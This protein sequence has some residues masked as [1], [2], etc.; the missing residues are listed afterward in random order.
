MS[1]RETEA[2]VKKVLQALA[3]SE[4]PAPAEA[5][6]E[7]DLT[8][9]YKEIEENLKNVLGTKA[10]IK[11]KSK[12]RGKIEI[13]YYSTDDMERILHLIYSIRN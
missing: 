10:S 2:F 8:P 6:A 4:A 7:V 1:V 9:I 3:A 13:E 12:D 11:A 5:A